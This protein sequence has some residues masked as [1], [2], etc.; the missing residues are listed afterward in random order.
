LNEVYDFVKKYGHLPGIPSAAEIQQNGLTIDLAVVDN[1]EKI[2]ELFLH[3][4]EQEEKIK[5]QQKENHDLKAEVLD[6]KKRLQLI[7][8][9][10]LEKK[11]N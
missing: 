2:E 1:L 8:E 4:I 6:L 3:T 9:L 10:L 7:E 5:A 11:S